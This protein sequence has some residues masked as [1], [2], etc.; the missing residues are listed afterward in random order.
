MTVA[1]VHAMSN[2]EYTGWQD[3]YAIK[4]MYGSV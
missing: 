4:R 1:E 2:D 3:Y